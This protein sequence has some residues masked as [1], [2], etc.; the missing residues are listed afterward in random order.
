MQKQ[1]KKALDQLHD[2]EKGK[3]RY[4][5]RQQEDKE[6]MEELKKYKGKPNE[7]N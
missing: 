1:K 4:R 6:S 3:I 7:Y 2:K 5:R